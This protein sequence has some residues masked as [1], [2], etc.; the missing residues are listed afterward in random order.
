[1]QS[2]SEAIETLHSS[3][4]LNERAISLLR[5]RAEPASVEITLAI[6]E[7]LARLGV[8][9]NPALESLRRVPDS[10]HPFLKTTVLGEKFATLTLLETSHG[11][12]ENLNR[13]FREVLSPAADASGQYRGVLGMALVKLA[14]QQFGQPGGEKNIQVMTDK[15]LPLR[16]AAEMHRQALAFGVLTEIKEL[17]RKRWRKSYYPDDE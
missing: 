7:T 2:I 4:Q 13:L 15:L 3:A 10:Y 5:T 9:D 1:V 12:D 17:P 6:A 8:Q 16:G 11:F 14:E